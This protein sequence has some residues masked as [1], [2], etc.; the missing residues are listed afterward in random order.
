MWSPDGATQ[1]TTMLPIEEEDAMNA[2]VQVI[3]ASIARTTQLRPR[4]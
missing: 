2:S 1:Q 4:K 3:L